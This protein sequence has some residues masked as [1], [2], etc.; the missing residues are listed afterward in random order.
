[1]PTSRRALLI[2]AL[3]L[4]VPSALGVN[5]SPVAVGFHVVVLFGSLYLAAL[6]LRR[7]A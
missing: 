5:S 7:R 1:M 3:L 6:A 2:Y 4:A